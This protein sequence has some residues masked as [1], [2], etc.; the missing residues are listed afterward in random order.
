MGEQQF[1]SL[2]LKVEWVMDGSRQILM[3]LKV[4]CVKSSILPFL[5]R[6]NLVIFNSFLLQM[7]HE[8][9]GFFTLIFF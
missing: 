7:G 8:Q 5:P 4:V 1:C 6:A 2:A 9:P 3:L